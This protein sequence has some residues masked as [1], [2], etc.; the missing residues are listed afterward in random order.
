MNR[1]NWSSWQ[2]MPD[3]KCYGKSLAVVLQKFVHNHNQPGV[4]Q[5]RNSKTA[6]F[7]LFGIGVNLARR[8]GSLLPKEHGGVGKRRNFRKR[9][10]VWD[11]LPNI[12][13]RTIC[14]NTRLEAQLI[15]KEIKNYNTHIFNT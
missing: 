7:I 1:L 5:L 9:D 3:P 13:F 12:E 14:C 4:Y 15:E 10:Y 6:E 8:M 2:S 11:H